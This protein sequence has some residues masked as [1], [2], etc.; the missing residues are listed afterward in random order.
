MFSRND[1]VCFYSGKAEISS[2]N[3]HPENLGKYTLPKPHRWLAGVVRW[4]ESNGRLEIQL[5]EPIDGW[6]GQRPLYVVPPLAVK[7]RNA[8]SSCNYSDVPLN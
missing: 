1:L 5:D 8:N 2:T 4:P 7:R 3:P 6:E